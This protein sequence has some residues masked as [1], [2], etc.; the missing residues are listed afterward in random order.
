MLSFACLVSGSHN[1]V[2]VYQLKERSS[3][4]F[5]F[6]SSPSVSSGALS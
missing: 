5:W 1:G 3:A 6:A 2:F 4:T